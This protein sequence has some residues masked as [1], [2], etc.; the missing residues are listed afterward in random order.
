MCTYLHQIF[1]CLTMRPRELYTDNDNGQSMV[2]LIDQMS[3]KLE[4]T[5][6]VREICKSKTGGLHNDLLSVLKLLFLVHKQ[7]D[8]ISST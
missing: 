3:Q 4:N 1:L 7:I 6:I 5:R 8:S 2:W